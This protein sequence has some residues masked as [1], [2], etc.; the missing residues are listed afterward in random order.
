MGLSLTL[1]PERHSNAHWFLAYSRL[2]LMDMS[3]DFGRVISNASSPLR[4]K[5]DIYGD[6]GIESVMDDCYGD[7]LTY[8]H[9]DTMAKLLEEMPSEIPWDIAV[10]AFVKA[11]PKDTRIVLWWH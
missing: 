9:A 2:P 6:D 5:I 1:L 7:P 4:Q 8:I 3:W 11:L 10:L